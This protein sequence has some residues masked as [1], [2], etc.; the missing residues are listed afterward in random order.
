MKKTVC[1]K[2]L[3]FLL[4]SLLVLMSCDMSYEEPVPAWDAAAPA[5]TGEPLGGSI[6]VAENFTLEVIAEAGDNGNLTYQWYSYTRYREY[7]THTGEIL[8]GETNAAYTASFDAEGVNHFY[9]IVTN[10]NL[11]A[12]GRRMVSVRSQPVTVVVNNSDNAKYPVIQAQPVGEKNIIWR[13]NIDIKPLMVTAVSEDEGE[14]SYQWYIAET[15]TNENGD[16]IEGAAAPLFPPLST[17]DG[18]GS[19]YYFVVVSNTNNAVPGRRVS[20]VVSNPVLISI[21]V[22]PNADVP[23]INEHPSGEIIFIGE[24]VSPLTVTAGEPEDGGDLSYQWYSNTTSSNEGGQRI[25]GATGNSYTPGISTGSAGRYYYYVVVTNTN[26]FATNPTSAAT[27]RAAELVVTTF[28]SDAE[29][30]P[31]AT[32]TVNLDDKLQFVR[33]F[34]GQDVAWGN[35]PDYRMTDYETMFNPDKLGYNMLR[36]QIPP[37]NIDINATMYDLITNQLYGTDRSR[38][39]YY[40]FVKLV[41]KYNGYVLASPWSP[42]MEWKTNNSKNGGGKLRPANYQDYAY[43]LRAFAQHMKNNGA[44]IYAISIQN[45]PNYEASGYDGC[46]WTGPEMRDFFKQVG[47]FT[48][49]G[50]QGSNNTLYP[51]NVPG[52]GG[53]RELPYVLTV[54]GESANN[55]NINNPALNDPDA[56]KYI[57]LL[58]RHIYGNRDTNLGG[59]GAGGANDP[60]VIY[61]PTDPREVWMTEFNLNS[62]TTA[63]YPND[64]TWNYLWQFLNTIDVSI[65]NNHES[66]YVWWSMKRFYSMIGDNTAGTVDGEVLPRGWGMAHYSKFAN[67]TYRTGVTYSGTLANGTALSSSNINPGN[68]TGLN[69]GGQAVAVKVMAFVRLRGGEVFPVNWKNRDV[70]MGDIT[71]ISL[72]MYTPTQ[73]TGNGGHD[74]GKVKLQLPDGFT[75]RGVTAMRSTSADVG[76]RQN[77]RPPVW[78]TVQINQERNA[79]YV[80]LPR[81]QIISVR[82]TR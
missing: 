31:N 47:R 56:K 73:P 40:E 3:G 14:L 32:I 27:S 46:E 38:E 8:E 22:S 30:N 23:I 2:T 6:D 10:T 74:M 58:A 76:N 11:K 54:N 65:R 81:S 25:T 52:F 44:P 55:V 49:Q 18:E 36:I 15:L 19:Y 48:Q 5:I 68:Y 60:N 43:Y 82:F 78:E 61:H 53:G 29:Q 28:S 69:T 13:R 24:N 1:L 66:A 63:A 21:I 16:L 4:A 59:T 50:R 12:T 7:E 17:I 45:E 9:V 70:D 75:I 71:E 42:P 57:D 20:S 67:E 64:S 41:N 72:V 26:T 62:Q 33:G 80:S 79:A 51:S 34:G 39:N 77:P 35:F 37:D